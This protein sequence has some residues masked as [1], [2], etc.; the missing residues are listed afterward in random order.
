MGWNP[1]SDPTPF[2]LAEYNA[3]ASRAQ[4]LSGGNGV[5]EMPGADV[6]RIIPGIETTVIGDFILRVCA[7]TMSA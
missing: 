5:A 6:S 7:V 2:V 1:Q 3:G 4:R